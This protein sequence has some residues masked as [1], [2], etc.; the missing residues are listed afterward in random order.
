[1]EEVDKNGHSQYITEGTL[2]ASHRAITDPPF[3]TI[4]LPY[5]RN[6]AEDEAV[7]SSEPVKLVFDLHLT[8]NIFDRGNRIRVT[9]TGADV[10]NALTPLSPPLR[11]AIYH[12]AN[13]L[14]YITLSII[15]ATTEKA[16]VKLAPNIKAA[17]P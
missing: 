12:H 9:I 3:E 6:F 4:A 1:M 13:Y 16:E 14:S 15:P 10:D 7:F 5:H 2:R 11:L 8:S 17:I